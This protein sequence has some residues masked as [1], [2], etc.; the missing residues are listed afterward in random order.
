[1]ESTPTLTQHTVTLKILGGDADV[2]NFLI[3]TRSNVMDLK[4]NV[5]N[6][7]IKA[8]QEKF[9]DT[10]YYGNAT[11]NAK[12][13]DGLHVL[14]TST[15]YNT[16]HEGSSATPGGLNI[17]N[18][19]AAIDL[20]TGFKPTHIAMSKTMR[21]GISVFLD[22]IGSAFPR[23]VN[24]YGKHIIMFDD[25]EIIVDDHITN[26]ETIASSAFSAS[27]GSTGTSIFVLTFG[28]E[29]ACC[30]VQGS[31]GVQVEPLGSLETKDATRTRIKWY[32]GLMLQAIRSCSKIDGIA[33]T[34]AVAA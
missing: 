28:G 5:V 15:T 29:Q 33:A 26:T 19:R 2:D 11:S 25:L 10:F 22:S 1:M 4:Q 23:G 6:D 30:G 31:A 13:F 3:A 21:R 7:K 14:M 9:L 18:L 16:V 8:V 24:E 17:S 32:T 12:E 27:T 20:V 34:T